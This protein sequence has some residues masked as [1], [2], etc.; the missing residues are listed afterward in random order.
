MDVLDQEADSTKADK[1][2]WVEL[3]VSADPKKP[4]ARFL[5]AYSKNKKAEAKRLEYGRRYRMAV[6][7]GGTQAIDAIADIECQA[8]AHAIVL[9]WENVHAGAE[10]IVCMGERKADAKTMY[11]LLK[12]APALRERLLEESS[13]LTNYKV[14]EDEEGLGN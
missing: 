14:A 4:V 1:G 8:L 13:R 7:A 10:E 5:L 11:E 9:G 6:Q 3:G 12:R 2:E